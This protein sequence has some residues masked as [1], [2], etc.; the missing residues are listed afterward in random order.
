ML[1]KRSSSETGTFGPCKCLTWSA[2]E[3][4]HDRQ[5][6]DGVA[7]GVGA[8]GL[9]GFGGGFGFFQPTV[10]YTDLLKDLL[11]CKY[12][13]SPLASVLRV[14]QHSQFSN[15]WVLVT[16][17]LDKFSSCTLLKRKMRVKNSTYLYSGKIFQSTHIFKFIKGTLYMHNF[18]IL[19]FN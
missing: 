2:R 9:G 12:A 16:H 11:Q 17:S 19:Y 4:S 8:S 5:G 7:D 10:K 15:L 3:W 14:L 6:S 1:S 18:F 13:G